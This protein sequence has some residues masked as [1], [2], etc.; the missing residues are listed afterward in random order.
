MV[1]GRVIKST[2]SWYTVEKAH[3][4]GT[5]AARIPGKMR[6]EGLKQTNPVAV[7]DRV[8]MEIQEDDT[9]IIKHIHPRENY[10]TRQATHGKRGEQII[11]ANIDIGIVVQSVRQPQFKTGFIDRFLIT[12]E[13]NNVH[14]LILINKLDLA[15]KDD[16][17]RL[18]EIRR[19]Y[20]SLGYELMLVSV[21]DDVSINMLKEHI[22]GKTVTLMGPSGTGKT[23]I[24]NTL[25]PDLKRT[26]AEVSGFSNKGKHTTTFAELLPIGDSSYVVD[27]P[28]IREFGLVDIDAAGLSNF[29]V[30]MKE[31]R[32]QCKYYN[33]T[34]V[35]EPGCAV[36]EAYDKGEI[37]PE[38]YMSYLQIIESLS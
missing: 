12:C 29:Y 8:D 32:T 21:A 10:L 9:G 5:I 14:P 4:E 31:L 37:H 28:G 25:N 20:E 15:R 36:M 11:A 18:D 13:A 30:E 19:L 23:T 3:N 17:T 27:T 26:T 16:L 22:S 33:C 35:H 2:G 7:G 6:L 38:R 1:S 24:L 34:H